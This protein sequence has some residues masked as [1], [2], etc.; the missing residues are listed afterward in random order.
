MASGD[1]DKALDALESAANFAAEFD[2]MPD[3]LPH[4][5]PMFTMITSEK[6]EARSS[7]FG[8]GK[9]LSETL[10][11]ELLELSCFEPLRYSEKLKTICEKL[12]KK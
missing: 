7:S 1:R 5:S 9:T 8:T 11:G 4:T 3:T 2:A 12:E 10:L 6:T